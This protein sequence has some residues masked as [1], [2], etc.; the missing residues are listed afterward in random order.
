MRVRNTRK[1]AFLSPDSCIVHVEKVTY[2]GPQRK[3]FMLMWPVIKMSDTPPL[4]YVKLFKILQ[5][6]M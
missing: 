1:Q 3:S 4:Q 2:G 6:K 5:S